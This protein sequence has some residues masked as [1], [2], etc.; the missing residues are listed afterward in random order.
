M[1]I[2]GNI[3]Y[4]RLSVNCGRSSN[5]DVDYWDNVSV[6]AEWDQRLPYN[7]YYQTFKTNYSI[8]FFN[9]KNQKNLSENDKTYIFS[10]SWTEL[11]EIYPD[12]RNLNQYFVDTRSP[13]QDINREN[14]MKKC[15][16]IMDLVCRSYKN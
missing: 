8:H 1:G 15:I 16:A 7:G 14:V 3:K 11:C 10:K 9:H 4:T 13:D 6:R 2:A 12:L 5:G